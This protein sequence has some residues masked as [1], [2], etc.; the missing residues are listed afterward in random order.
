[1]SFD[2]RE[3]LPTPTEFVAL[4]DAAG[5]APRSPAAAEVGLPNSLYGVTVVHD[6]TVV[7]MGRVVG[8][9]GTVF[10]LTDTVVHPDY[11]G[12]GLGTEITRAL[13]DWVDANA[14]PSAYVNLVADVEGFY[15]RFGFEPTAPA[16][17]AMYRRVE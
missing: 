17:H 13:V 16:S 2:L 9:G 10:Q 5:M 7:G 1:M 4:R 8:D 15:E 12:Q 3:S 14:P 6:E 11:Q